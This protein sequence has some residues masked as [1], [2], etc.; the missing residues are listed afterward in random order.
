MG[1]LLGSFGSV[2][3]TPKAL[4]ESPMGRLKAT[5]NTAAAIIPMRETGLPVIL[6]FSLIA[7]ILQAIKSQ[8]GE[9]RLYEMNT[10][11]SLPKGAI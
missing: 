5:A 2:G 8:C 11:S 3:P 6:D 10:L 7:E 9:G 4:L 1:V